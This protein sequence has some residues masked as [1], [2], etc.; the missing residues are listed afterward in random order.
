[1]SYS[2]IPRWLPKKT[3]HCSLLQTNCTVKLYM[4]LV[5]LSNQLLS[6]VP[7][8]SLQLHSCLCSLCF[9][10]VANCVPQC[11]NGGM[12]LKPQFCICKPGSEGK[13]CEQQTASE[14]TNGHTNVQTHGHTPGLTNGHTTGQNVVPQR[15]IPQQVVP[16]GYVPGQNN[17]AQMKLTV[18]PAPQI[19]RPHYIQQHIQQQ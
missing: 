14:P 10:P 16:G 13:H 11:Q 12:C 9:C 18:K 5:L 1:M 19:V 8:F 3:S 6:S 15:P 2:K 17:M 4:F 7:G